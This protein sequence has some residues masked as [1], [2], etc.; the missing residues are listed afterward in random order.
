MLAVDAMLDSAE[1]PH[2]SSVLARITEPPRLRDAIVGR[3]LEL[4]V[5]SVE[6]AR[7]RVRARI[8]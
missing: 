5:Q 7:E 3:L 8:S 1:I 6:A 2:G 4:F